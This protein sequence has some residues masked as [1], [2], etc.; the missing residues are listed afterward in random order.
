MAT[1]SMEITIPSG[2]TKKKD[3]VIPTTSFREIFDW[4]NLTI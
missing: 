1:T 3:K 4:I 2:G